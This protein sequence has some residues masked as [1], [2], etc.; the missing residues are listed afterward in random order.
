MAATETITIPQRFNGPLESGN[1]GYSAGV[2]AAF[3]DGPVE[4]SLRRPVPLDTPLEIRRG[5][6][7]SVLA[8]DGD[9][10]VAEGRPGPELELDVPAAVSLA[11]ARAARQLYRGLGTGSFANCFVCGRAR[12]DAFG[13]QAG[14]VQ[15]RDVVA[16]PWT[17]PEWTADESGT[18]R[19]EIV[20][21]VLDCPTYFATYVDVP[22]PLPPAVLARFSVRIDAPVRAGD[23]HV[24]IGWP[25]EAD[26]RKRR[27]GS[28]VVSS[29]GELLAV[30]EALLIEP[31]GT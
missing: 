31:R 12:D 6:D 14:R 25:I 16:S 26:G 22:D 3:A 30:A 4:V 15:S 10:L 9:E 8:V 5:E 19:P 13:V 23:E 2:L 27:A 29:D 18:V 7:G 24:A 11:D 28:A 21:A 1:G 17:P 20:W